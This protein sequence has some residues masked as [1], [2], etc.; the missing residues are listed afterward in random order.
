MNCVI[1]LL[2]LV[3]MQGTVRW[4]TQIQQCR[5]IIYNYESVMNEQS[6]LSGLVP[7]HTVPQHFVFIHNSKTLLRAAGLCNPSA[8][9]D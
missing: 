2:L 1:Y 4:I 6:V 7:C 3:N 5:V 9:A 8:G